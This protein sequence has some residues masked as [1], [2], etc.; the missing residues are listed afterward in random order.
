VRLVA[1]TMVVEGRRIR[2]TPGMTV[3]VDIKTGER[4]IMEYILQ[5]ILRYAAEGLRER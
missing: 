1:E 5:P 3:T 2:L 4:R